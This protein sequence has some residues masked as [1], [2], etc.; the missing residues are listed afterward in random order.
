MN[1]RR[2]FGSVFAVAAVS[3]AAAA[4]QQGPADIAPAMPAILKT[5]E[6]G[7]DGL[8]LFNIRAVVIEPSDGALWIKYG[9]GT[10]PAIRINRRSGAITT[11][12]RHGSGPNEYRNIWAMAPGVRGEVGIWDTMRRSWFWVDSAGV[13][14]R[15]WSVPT[16]SL[17]QSV[18]TDIRGNVYIGQPVRFGDFSNHV[19]VRVDS[20]RGLVDSTPLPVAGSS[21]YHWTYTSVSGGGRSSYAMVAPFAP[22]MMWGVD[23]RGRV[24]GAWSDSNFVVVRDG[25]RDRKLLLPD[26]RDPLSS[27]ERAQADSVLDGFARDARTRG[28]QLD[29]PRPPVPPNRPQFDEL[30][31]DMTGGIAVVRSR[32]CS[33]LPGWRAPG[34]AAPANDPQSRCGLVERFDSAGRRLR[35]FTLTHGHQLKVLR[36]DT[37]WVIAPAGDGLARVIEMVIPRAQ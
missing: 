37:A 4:F 7:P 13:Q 1:S 18:F 35:P 20:S 15:T 27:S 6:R 16:N 17:S 21:K 9:R 32:Q 2:L 28:A 30:I 24:F 10:E 19:A 31:A 22:S 8:E 14:R 34:G 12:G 5:Y 26:Y 29:G 36:G 23:A 33:A 3:G 25:T 11:I